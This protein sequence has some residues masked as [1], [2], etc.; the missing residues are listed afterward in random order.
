MSSNQSKGHRVLIIDDQD[1]NG[2]L[3]EE[4]SKI[5]QR[6]STLKMVNLGVK[7]Q[8]TVFGPPVTIDSVGGI[9][10]V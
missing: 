4:T 3:G 6:G 9:V 1:G 10:V 7:I 8:G 2:M 5:Y